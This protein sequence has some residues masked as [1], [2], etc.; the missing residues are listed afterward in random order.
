MSVK[1]YLKLRVV[2][3]DIK[4]EILLQRIYKVEKKLEKIG[5]KKGKEPERITFSNIQEL[6]PEFSKE[7]IDCGIKILEEMKYVSAKCGEISITKKGIRSLNRNVI[8]ITIWTAGIV[9]LSISAILF[10]LYESDRLYSIL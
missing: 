10:F 8:I 9:V 6:I 3:Y 1:D 2:K 7:E 4:T 5:R